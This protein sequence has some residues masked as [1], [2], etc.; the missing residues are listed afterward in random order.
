[1]SRWAAIRCVVFDFDGTLVE[2]NPI[3]RGTYFEIL[4]ETPGSGAVVETVLRENPGADRHRVLACAHEVLSSRGAS[5]LPPL[6]ALVDAYSRICEE[7]VAACPPLPGA[8]ETLE[9]LRA[10]HA[11]SLDSA[12]P[13]EA[14]ERVIEK[15]GWRNFFRGVLGGPVSKLDN[16]RSIAQREGVAAGEMAYVGDGPADR[17]AA[18]TFGCR[19]LGFEAPALDL[20]EGSPLAVLVAEIAARSVGTGRSAR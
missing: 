13:T 11:L 9:S 12:T 19:F 14:L 4:A 16:L 2:S 1:M 5:P 20:P 18:A 17:E 6:E 7:R 8:L 15:R 10:T 3:K